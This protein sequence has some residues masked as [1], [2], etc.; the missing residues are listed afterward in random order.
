[1]AT[2]FYGDPARGGEVSRRGFIAAATAGVVTARWSNP[3]HVQAETASPSPAN[4]VDTHVYLGRWPFRQTPGNSAA[5]TVTALRQHGVA[6]AWAGTFEGLLHKDVSG[7][8]ARLAEECRRTGEKMLIPFGVVNPTLPDWEEDVRRC[9]ETFKMPG[10]RLHPNYHGYTLADERFANLLAL[11]TKRR[12]LLQLVAQL[13][14]AQ[15]AYLRMPSARVDLSPLAAVAKQFPELRL[16]LHNR[17]ER[18]GSAQLGALPTAANVYFDVTA[19]AA[20]SA[21]PA[22]RLVLGSCWPLGNVES[23]LS[24]GCV[25]VGLEVNG[26]ACCCE[27]AHQLLREATGDFDAAE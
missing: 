23:A 21:I 5:E 17:P 18:F 22:N 3:A 2:D 14:D 6:Q 16:T 7:A 25:P 19:V 13:D 26:D 9:H 8:N 1:M 24:R 20:S 11:A 4:I 10:I 12:M 15:H 27:T